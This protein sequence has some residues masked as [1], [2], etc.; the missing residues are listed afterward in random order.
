MTVMTDESS[1][2]SSNDCLMKDVTVLI[3]SFVDGFSIFVNFSNCS[4]CYCIFYV[5][6]YALFVLSVHVNYVNCNAKAH[7]EYLCALIK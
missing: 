2:L 7:M 6:M 1:S 3:C 4:S 5:V